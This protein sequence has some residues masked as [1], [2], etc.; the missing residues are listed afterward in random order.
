MLRVDLLSGFL[1]VF[2]GTGVFGFGGD[3]GPANLAQFSGINGLAFRGTTLL[4]ADNA[5]GRIRAIVPSAPLTDLIIELTTSQ[6][7]L[8]AIN[9]VPGSVLMINVDGRELL[10]VPNATSVGLDVTLTD[11]DQLIVIDLNAL[12]SVGGDITISGNLALQSIDMSSLTTIGGG[13][14]ITNNPV[15]NAILISGVTSIGGDLTVIGTAATVIDMSALTTVTGSIDVSGNTLATAIDMGS[16]TSV[17]G[18]LSSTAT[19]RPTDRH[20][21]SRTAL[22]L[23]V[24]GN[25]SIDGSPPAA[26]STSRQ[27]RARAIDMGSLTTVGGA[28]VRQ[29]QH[30]GRPDRHGRRSRTVT[31]G[32][33]P[34]WQHLGRRLDLSTLDS[35]G[36]VDISGNTSAGAVDM[37][38]LTHA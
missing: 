29:Q 25:V 35:A 9:A 17:G 37:S 19:R 1:S 33:S 31:G 27:L 15:L 12:A 34:S 36:G 18:N 13:L 22:D 20:A 26:T 23:S 38:G 8:D 24:T 5:N 6:D 16:L 14:N 30:L 2:A 28:H 3:G 32:L 21:A 7:F 11:N 10:I 4:I